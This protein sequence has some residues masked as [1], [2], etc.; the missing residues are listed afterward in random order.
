MVKYY[1][2]NCPYITNSKSHYDDHVN[3]IFP[4]SADNMH[5]NIKP[6]QESRCDVCNKTF[7]NKASLKRH[8]N[9]YHINS[10]DSNNISNDTNNGNINLLRTIDGPIHVENNAYNGNTYISNNNIGNIIINTDKYGIHSYQYVNI[11]DLTILEQYLSLAY[12]VVPYRNI[13]DNL[14]FHPDKPQYHNIRPYGKKELRMYD[15]KMWINEVVYFAMESIIDT[16][17]T[18]L[19]SIFNRFRIFLGIRYHRYQLYH[20][21][22]GLPCCTKEYKSLTSEI[23][24]HL[25][26]KIDPK[27]YPNITEK[28]IPPKNDPIWHHLSKTFTWDE[29]E[30][31]LVEMDK[32]GI[33]FDKDLFDINQ[34]IIGYIKQ[35]PNKKLRILFKKMVN[36]IKILIDEY[37][38]CTE[39]T[40]SS[41]SI[42]YDTEDESND[43][44][45]QIT[46]N[47]RIS[48]RKPSKTFEKKI[49]SIPTESENEIRYYGSNIVKKPA[50]EYIIDF[51][52]RTSKKSSKKPKK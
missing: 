12:G 8:N 15:G 35:N 27:K 29:V 16:G 41:E 37:K 26:N 34:Q 7:S 3:R 51:E 24:C 46:K 11:N 39:L 10:H 22:T 32:M 48:K 33:N 52:E 20:L 44:D 21:Y 6:L 1:C 45:N 14:N 38:N 25:N 49:S 2:D 4:C 9:N 13:L 28:N 42:E 18:L 31:Y 17:R 23:L 30:N 43:N 5:K 47:N 36:R 19:C 50:D 40:S